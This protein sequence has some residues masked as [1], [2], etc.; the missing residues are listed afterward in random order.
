MRII[1]TYKQLTSD[2]IY[3]RRVVENADDSSYLR[4]TP[5]VKS[6][7]KAITYRDKARIYRARARNRATC[8]TFWLSRKWICARQE[9][10]GVTTNDEPLGR[11]RIQGLWR[12][13]QRNELGILDKCDI[14]VKSVVKT[15][16]SLRS[17]AHGRLW[18]TSADRAMDRRRGNGGAAMRQR[19]T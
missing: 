14:Y 17:V 3:R 13:M 4:S 6:I 8:R 11:A 9:T 16:H 2:R 18:R 7:A 1:N 15:S 19:S 5:D 12:N 10:N